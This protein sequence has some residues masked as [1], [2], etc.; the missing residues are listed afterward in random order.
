[1]SLRGRVSFFVLSPKAIPIL[2]VPVKEVLRDMPPSGSLDT[3]TTT[4]VAYL[5]R[6]GGVPADPTTIRGGRR[7]AA[8]PT[9]RGRGRLRP[10]RR[11]AT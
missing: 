4:M 1:M 11:R 8:T 3:S 2:T 5:R 10:R 7:T 9:T 6:C